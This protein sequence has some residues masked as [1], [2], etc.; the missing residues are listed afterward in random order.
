MEKKKYFV[1]VGSKE[2]SQ[3]PY[4]DN[5]DFKIQATSEEVR[6]LRAK[7]DDMHDAEFTNFLRAHVPIMSYHKDRSN[8]EYDE[9]ITDAFRMIY[10]LGDEETR[11]H[12][13]S[14]N[15][16]DNNHKDHL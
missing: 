16:L 13:R 5:A 12:I 1:N 3:I 11:E 7:M 4:H 6:L 9:G 8:D 10:E 14:M 2:I 15:V